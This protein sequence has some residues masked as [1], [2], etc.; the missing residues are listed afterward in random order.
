MK[1]AFRICAL[2]LVA[3]ALAPCQ[4]LCTDWL[5]G[6]DE[7]V[8]RTEDYCLVTLS[9]SCQ[10]LCNAEG[11]VWDIAAPDAPLGPS[12]AGLVKRKCGAAP[13]S[14]T[15]CE[16]P[17]GVAAVIFKK[18]LCEVRLE[19]ESALVVPFYGAPVRRAK[20][21]DRPLTPFE[22]ALAEAACSIR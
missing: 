22:I 11:K 6:R 20:G 4:A 15:L 2:T 5:S 8:S 21:D 17:D 7:T 12:L 1:Q 16:M 19:D 9:E 18:S 10:Y 14:Q 3:F 13:L